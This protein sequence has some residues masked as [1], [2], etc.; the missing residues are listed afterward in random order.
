MAETRQVNPEDILS[1]KALANWLGVPES[2]VPNLKGLGMPFIQVGR[3]KV[4][5]RASSVVSWLA[6]REKSYQDGE[7]E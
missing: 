2:E 7:P 4:V 1:Q 3:G 5:F 6:S